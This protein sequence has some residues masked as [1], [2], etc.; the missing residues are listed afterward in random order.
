MISRDARCVFVAPNVAEATVVVNWLEHEGI[1]A[2]VMDSMT[3][4]GLEGLTAWTGIS[5]RGIEVWVMMKEDAQRAV[6][7]IEHHK[8][9]IAKLRERKAAAGPVRAVCEECEQ[10]SVFSGDKRG[11]V[12]NCP[13]CGS[14]LDV[15]GGASGSDLD[16]IWNVAGDEGT[17]AEETNRAEPRSSPR[18]QSALRRLQKP[19]ILLALGCAALWLL[20]LVLSAVAVHLSR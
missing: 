14:Y 11:S 5:A 7:L 15:P 4:G 12:Q 9:A 16:E 19:I 18:G 2:Q 8:V 6:S 1:A 17:E 10:G 13:H 3:H 20:A